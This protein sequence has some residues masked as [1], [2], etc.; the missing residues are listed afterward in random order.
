MTSLDFALAY[1]RTGWS[2]FPLHT[3]IDGVCDCAKGVDCQSPGKHPR[4]RTGNKEATTDEAKIRKW[5]MRWPT[6]NI[7]LLTGQ[8]SGVVVL[9]VDPKDG[10]YD[11]LG[12][13]LVAA[14][15]E[16]VPPTKRVK[17]GKANGERGL[18]CYFRVPEGLEIRNRARL[19]GYDGIDLRGDGG[20]VVAPP[21]LHAS[22]VRY[23]WV[24]GTDGTKPHLLDLPE[25]LL[26]LIKG[27]PTPKAANRFNTERALAGVPEGERDETLWRLC[28]RLRHAGVPLKFAETLVLGAADECEPPFPQNVALEKVRRCYRT[29][30]SDA[31]DEPLPVS[32]P[33]IVQLS[34]V[35]PEE[36]EWLWE[37]FIPRGKL[38][39]MEGDPG[40]GKTFVALALATAL[41]LGHGLP[42]VEGMPPPPDEPEFGPTV[43]MSAED[44][45]ADTICPRLD[46]MDADR[47]LIYAIEGQKQRDPVTGKER[48]VGITLADVDVLD[49]A[50]DKIRPALLV[51]DPLQ[52]YLGARV[53]FHRANEVRP[54]LSN[55]GVLAAKHRCAVLILRHLAKSGSARS[56]YRGL[57]SI[58]FIA[59]ARSVLLVGRPV[60]DPVARAIVHQ[61]CSVGPLGPSIGFNIRD[62]GDFGWTGASSMTASDLLAAEDAE[63]DAPARDEAEEF[64]REI[65]AHGEKKPSKDVLAEARAAGISE[66]TLRRAKQRLGVKASRVGSLNA[67]GKG[68]WLWAMPMAALDGSLN[69]REIDPLEH[70]GGHLG[71]ENLNTEQRE[72]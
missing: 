43:Y 56:I 54:L 25:G 8:K 11:S 68:L 14:G 69:G 15:I 55:L 47:G 7:G 30:E 24:V 48:L 4:T 36:V 63:G 35:E 9:D 59:A 10:G 2:V 1:A 50:L 37:P 40:C 6:A 31:E 67:R 29:Y 45:L 44:G 19:A 28:G 41:S 46:R 3:P 21:S 17:T 70:T 52:A 22:G 5:W 16:G 66:R 27:L 57:G 20:Y 64:L 32:T 18:H 60:D 61:K 71:R 49:A 26:S 51:L 58:D 34:D 12:K 53:D 42:W 33:A 72:S 65:L 13:A 62:G 38:T 39:I 23:E